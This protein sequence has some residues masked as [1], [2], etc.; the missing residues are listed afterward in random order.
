V[1]IPF[2]ARL[3]E[4]SPSFTPA[5]G[6][7]AE[8]NEFLPKDS[9]EYKRFKSAGQAEAAAVLEGQMGGLVVQ[10]GAAPEGGAAEG[11][12]APVP[13]PEKK[14]SSKKKSKDPEVV[15][16]RNTRNKKKCV[17]TVIGLDLFGVKLNEASKLFGKKFASGASVVKNAEL[18]EQIDIQGDCLDGVAELIV[19]QF[20][21]VKKADVYYI[22]SKKKERYFGDDVVD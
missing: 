2:P 17:T 22:E 13:T 14:K 20:K 19:K 3:S 21:E 16:E 7:P 4:R 10:D 15:L 5:A 8:F 9:E 1:A 18:K 6:V 11:A 12:A